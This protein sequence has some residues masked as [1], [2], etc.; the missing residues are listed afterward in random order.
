MLRN[1]LLPVTQIGRE[2]DAIL[3]AAGTVVSQADQLDYV[4][5]TRASI[6]AVRAGVAAD[7]VTLHKLL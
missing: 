1:L 3:A 7:G 2:A 6:K 4:V 5:H